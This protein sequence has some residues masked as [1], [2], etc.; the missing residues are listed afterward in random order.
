V[1]NISS[2]THHGVGHLFKQLAVVA[3]LGAC[4]LAQAGVLDFEGPNADTPFI[5]SGDVTTFGDYWV[6]SYGGTQT[7]DLVGSVVEGSDNGLCAGIACPVNNA[8]HYY[9]A[10]NDGYVYFGRNDNVNFALKS[11]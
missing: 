7:G 9:A 10:L 6:A 1:A 3:A 2:K 4:S 5:F 11:L 8:S